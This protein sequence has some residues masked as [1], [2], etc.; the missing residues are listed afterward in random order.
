MEKKSTGAHNKP[1]R[2]RNVRETSTEPRTQSRDPHVQPRSKTLN[3]G[4]DASEMGRRS[5]A[6]RRE[7]KQQREEHAEENALTFRQRLGVSL[8]KLTQREL[9]QRVRD[10]RPS[11]LVRFADQ[12]F[13]KP[14]PAED[15]VPEDQGLASLTREQRAVLRQMLEEGLGQEDQGDD[16]QPI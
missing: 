15:D 9:D 8:S 6:A 7:K 4:L 3:G 5:G 14:L 13:G 10:A 1:E 2:H 11:E 12:A 16:T